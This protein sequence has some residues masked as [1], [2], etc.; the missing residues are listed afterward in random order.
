MIHSPP[1]LRAHPLRTP[2]RK[3]LTRQ[4]TGDADQ[5]EAD[6]HAALAQYISQIF[7]RDANVDD[8]GHHQRHQQFKNCFRQLEQRAEHEFF[9]KISE[10]R[11]NRFHTNFFLSDFTYYTSA[12]DIEKILVYYINYT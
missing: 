3:I 5:C 2:R 9:F 7:L 10:I 8:P 6:D 4:G 1:Q 12:L 11:N